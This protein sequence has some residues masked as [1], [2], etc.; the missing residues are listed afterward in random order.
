MSAE[1]IEELRNIAADHAAHDPRAA[2][3][4]ERL[5]RELAEAR[6]REAAIRR[7]KRLAAEPLI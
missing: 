2:P 4:F 5:E 6:R 7:A 1:E 3:I